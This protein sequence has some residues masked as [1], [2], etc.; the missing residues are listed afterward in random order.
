MG[1][2]CTTLDTTLISGCSGKAVQMDSAGRVFASDQDRKCIN[3]L[4]N[5][6]LCSHV[7]VYSRS[8]RQ[9]ALNTIIN[10]STM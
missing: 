6:H 10:P 5:C 1:A 8:S 4:S 7:N 3:C 9:F 2:L